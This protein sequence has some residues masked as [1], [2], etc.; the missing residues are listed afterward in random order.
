L[1]VFSRR[2]VARAPRA[3][4]FWP[5]GGMCL[6]AAV[7]FLYAVAGTVAPRWVAALMMLV[8]LGGFVQACAWWTPH[9]RRITVLAVALTV[10]W[11]AVLVGGGLLFDWDA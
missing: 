5:F 11:F 6:M 3:T 1:A 10:L 9:P 4:D 8:W 2:R 7:F